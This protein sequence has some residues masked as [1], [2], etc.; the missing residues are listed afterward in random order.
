MIRVA[1]VISDTN[2]GGAGRLLVTRLKNTDR[3]EFDV[4]V[5][6]PYGSELKGVLEKEKIGYSEFDGCADRSFDASAI[7]LLINAFRI[8]DPD[9][10]NTH[11]CLSA[12]IAAALIRVPVRISTRHCAY[13][14]SKLYSVPP[15][16]AVGGFIATRLSNRFIAVADAAAENL[17]GMGIPAKKTEIIIN[18]TDR[19]EKY[20]ADRKKEAR[21]KLG[22]PEGAFAVGICARLEECKGIDVFLR[23]ARLLFLTNG[24]YYFLIAGKGSREKELRCLCHALGIDENVLFCG[25]IKDVTDFF[26]CIDL[27][28]NCS[29]GTETSSL[30]LSEGMSIGLP[31]VASD[32]GGNPYMVRDGENGLIFKTDDFYGLS[33]CIY[34]L[35]HDSELYKRM[36]EGAIRRFDEELNSK[37]M[38]EK[39]EELYKRLYNEYLT[40]KKSCIIN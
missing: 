21:K 34:T 18:G 13:P 24:N 10:V 11:G 40:V 5:F 30:A 1:E 4:R 14:V 31:A 16:R 20:P 36:S 26:N 12:R 8:F 9:I 7:P 23:A 22:I 27:N 25:F 39:T 15:V 3:S 6:L 33:K 38:T 17:T 2:T 32:Y 28:V 19:L 35:S 37:I 29:R